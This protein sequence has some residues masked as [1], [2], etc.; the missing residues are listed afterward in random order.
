M[1]TDALSAPA[2]PR[3]PADD[4]KT[5]PLPEVEKRLATSADGLT[6]VQATKRLTTYGPNEIAEHH[7]NALLKF[8][9]YFWARSRG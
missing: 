9:S 7:T 6:Q 1:K 3:D 2:A 8:L 5:L 4:L